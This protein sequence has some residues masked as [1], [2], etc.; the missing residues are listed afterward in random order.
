MIPDFPAVDATLFWHDGVW[1]LFCG[2]AGDLSDSEL[3]I[4]HAASPRGPWRPHRQ[5]PVKIDA[6]SSRPAGPPIVVDGVLYRP[7]QDCSCTYGGALIINRVL[8]L[9]R[10]RFAEE[11]AARLE[12]DP[13]GPYPDG[14]HTLCGHG[15]VTLV[16]GKRTCF[17]IAAP[18]LKAWGA[19]AHRRRLRRRAQFSADAG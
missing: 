15:N 8:V 19:L 17:H 13:A 1:W 9:D 2:R 12:P 6:R 5:N 3:F 16:D 4:W 7:A 14:L 11:I 10:E 18:A